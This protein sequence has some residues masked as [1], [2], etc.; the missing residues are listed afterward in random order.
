[1]RAA[2]HGLAGRRIELSFQ[3]ALNHIMQLATVSTVSI[4]STRGDP[5]TVVQVYLSEGVGR[6]G[7]IRCL[8]SCM[9]AAEPPCLHPQLGKV[10]VNATIT[11]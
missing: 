11:K 6:R 7:L 4:C 5:N 8:V 10:L 2:A 9:A 3:I 1:M